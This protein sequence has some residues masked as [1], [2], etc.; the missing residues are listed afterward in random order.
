MR[1]HPG[2][3]AVGR[4]PPQPCGSSVRRGIAGTASAMTAW[5]N[6]ADG[7]PQDEVYPGFEPEEGAL[8]EEFQP[9][10]RADR[11]RQEGTNATPG[12][13]HEPVVAFRCRC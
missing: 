11:L 12:P 5:F 9:V 10:I 2:V 1:T 8:R 4:R 13:A 3:F 6:T 7:L